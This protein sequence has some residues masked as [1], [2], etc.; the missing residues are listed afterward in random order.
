[1]KTLM[2]SVRGVKIDRDT[3]AGKELNERWSRRWTGTKDEAKQILW[4]AGT[5]E[6]ISGRGGR[7]EK[8]VGWVQ[9]EGGGDYNFGSCTVV[10]VVW[11]VANE[12]HVRECQCNV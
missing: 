7:Q 6:K 12:W 11:F 8:G 3:D 9:W 5:L 10:V 1:M 4:L 2:N